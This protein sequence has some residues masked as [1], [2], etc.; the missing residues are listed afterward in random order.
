MQT[1]KVDDV[2]DENP[3]RS[4]PHQTSKYRSHVP[5]CLFFS[6]DTADIT[7]AVNELCQRKT[8]P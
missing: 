5:R 7:F 2:K 1:P 3:V 6:P 4:D 8:D